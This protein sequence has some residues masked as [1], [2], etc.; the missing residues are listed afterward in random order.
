MKAPEKVLFY[1]SYIVKYWAEEEFW[2]WKR[3]WQG[4]T[5]I[6]LLALEDR[7]I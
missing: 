1:F 4:G 5:Q 3:G 7:G 2:L 6:P